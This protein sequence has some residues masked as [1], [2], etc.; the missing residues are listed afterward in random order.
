MKKI[1]F[2]AIIAIAA[3]KKK[4][5]LYSSYP[6]G[7]SHVLDSFGIVRNRVYVENTGIKVIFTSDSI[8]ETDTTTNVTTSF[9]PHV[10]RYYYPSDKKTYLVILFADNGKHEYSGSPPI[11]NTIHNSLIFSN[12]LGYGLNMSVDVGKVFFGNIYIKP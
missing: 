4:E 3:C 7:F 11:Q 10:V 9:K 12:T 5:N 2:F 6:R 8:T 1:L